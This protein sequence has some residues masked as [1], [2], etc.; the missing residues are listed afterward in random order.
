MRA[1]IKSA[2]VN[3]WYRFSLTFRAPEEK[4]MA[5]INQS[6]RTSNKNIHSDFCTAESWR[7]RE[8]HALYVIKIKE[9]SM[10]DLNKHRRVHWLRM[11]STVIIDS[12]FIAQRWLHGMTTKESELLSRESNSKHD[13][14]VWT[15]RLGN[16]RTLEIFIAN[17]CRCAVS[18]WCWCVTYDT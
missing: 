6:L 5:H 14:L 13:H 11:L 2:A 17:Y 18:H 8:T 15:L 12:T 4:I 9:D 10:Y 1:I 7:K 3:S 16:H